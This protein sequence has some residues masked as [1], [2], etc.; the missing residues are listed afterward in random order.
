VFEVGFTEILLILV[1]VLI[2]AGPERM[3]GI[4]RGVG[5]AVGRAKA[6][7]AQLKH[8]FDRELEA[9]ELKELK[10]DAD[11]ARAEVEAAARDIERGDD[12]RR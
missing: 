5:R 4:V 6:L 7:A 8:E 12:E 9:Q 11:A 10:R 2:V 1:L 3:P